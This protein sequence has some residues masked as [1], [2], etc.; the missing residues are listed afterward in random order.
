MD[1]TFYFLCIQLHAI[2]SFQ[3]S[4]PA[5]FLL[6]HMAIIMA[7]TMPSKGILYTVQYFSSQQKRLKT[8]GLYLRQTGD[9]TEMQGNQ[10]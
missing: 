7:G 8:N 3:H 4:K 2:D 6:T 9:G 5:Q 1:S 10:H